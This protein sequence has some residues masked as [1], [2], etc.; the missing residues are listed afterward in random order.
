MQRGGQSNRQGGRETKT[1][2]QKQ[3][4]RHMNT[5]TQK[6]RHANR[7]SVTQPRWERDKKHKVRH[8]KK[9]RQRDT[10]TD[11]QSNRNGGGQIKKHKNTK[12]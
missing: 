7:H 2:A 4:V 6:Q 3:K 12:I 9:D 8:T 1:H 10:L 5:Q 11:A